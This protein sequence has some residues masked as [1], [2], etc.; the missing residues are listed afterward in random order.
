[1]REIVVGVD[2]S[3]AAADATLRAGQL[4][5]E[6][7]AVLTVVHVHHL[8]SLGAP[9]LLGLEDLE[10]GWKQA[11][12][13]VSRRAAEVLGPL[14]VPWRFEVRTGETATELEALAAERG[15]DMVVVGNRGHGLG[16]RLLLGS[17][18]NRLIQH[19]N[20]PVLVVR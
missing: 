11:D 10:L 5:K 7:G 8:P 16:H 20:R 2:G 1:V 12:L 15:A 3:E 13:L 17:V 9:Q 14:G 18:S 6:S 19:A 4:A